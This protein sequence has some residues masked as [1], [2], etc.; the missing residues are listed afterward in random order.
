MI[1]QVQ[2][3]QQTCDAHLYRLDNTDSWIILNQ[4]EFTDEI[5]VTKEWERERERYALHVE[6][7]LQM[8][9]NELETHY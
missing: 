5:Q 8:N 7:Y 6:I 2:Q 4:S 3:Q 1:G 9:Q